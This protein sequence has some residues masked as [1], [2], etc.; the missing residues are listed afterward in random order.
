MQMKWQSPATYL[1]LAMMWP[2][3]PK[4]NSERIVLQIENGDAGDTE[5][6][7]E[8]EEM[9]PDLEKGDKTKKKKKKYLGRINYKVISPL[10]PLKTGRRF[11]L[12]W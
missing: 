10:L 2:K 9:D 11:Q 8:T 4:L 1:T 6:L 7:L 5:E 12:F 3:W